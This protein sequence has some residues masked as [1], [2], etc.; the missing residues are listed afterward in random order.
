MNIKGIEKIED[1][2]ITLQDGLEYMDDEDWE[3]AEN[4]MEIIGQNGNDGEHYSKHDLNKDGI[5]EI[6]IMQQIK[7]IKNKV[8]GNLQSHPEKL[9]EEG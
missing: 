5:I 3:E 7:N 4:R 2:D 6:I 9:K 1:F 8:G